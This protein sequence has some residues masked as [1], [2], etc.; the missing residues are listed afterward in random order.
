MYTHHKMLFR[1]ADEAECSKYC[2]DTEGCYCA[3]YSSFSSACTLM[4]ED[5]GACTNYPTDPE[6]LAYAT[7]PS[8]QNDVTVQCG[9]FDFVDYSYNYIYI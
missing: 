3:Y 8:M 5:G 1:V 2:K 9:D 4:S 7:L 6:A